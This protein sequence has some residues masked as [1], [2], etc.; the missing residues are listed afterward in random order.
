MSTFEA[1]PPIFSLVV[2]VLNE[3]E[4]IAPVCREIAECLD[5]LPPCEVIFVND[6]ST[7]QTLNTLIKA[8]HSVLPHLRIL[9]HDRRLGKSAA[10][11]TGI[12]AAHGQ[13]IAT[14]DGDGQDNPLEFSSMLAI[15]LKTPENP[16]LVVGIR[17]KRHDRLSRKIATKLANGFRQFLLKDKCPDTGAPMKVFRRSDFLR[18]PQ[19]EGLHRFL[20]ALMQKYR[21]K[22]VCYPVKHRS[23]LYGSS[24]YTNFNRAIVGIGDLMGVMWFLSRTHLP[25]DIKEQ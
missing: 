3:A 10:L 8:K 14:M 9:S 12:E 7:D 13:W 5:K 2:T 19:F 25:R 6:G 24:K 15:A 21:I 4:N 16:S 1:S 22:L 18:L 20:P 17:L 11:R 23:R